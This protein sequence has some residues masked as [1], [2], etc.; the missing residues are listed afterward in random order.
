MFLFSSRQTD[1]DITVLWELD[2]RK[3]KNNLIIYLTGFLIVKSFLTWILKRQIFHENDK[4]LKCF[5]FSLSTAN[6]NCSNRK[7]SVWICE[8]VIKFT[9]YQI[10]QY[11]SCIA[12]PDPIVWQQ[13]NRLASIDWPKSIVW[14]LFNRMRR[15]VFKR[16]RQSQSIELLHF[17]IDFQRISA[18]ISNFIP[19]YS[20]SFCDCAGTTDSEN[21][22]EST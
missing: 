8:N 9:K 14:D 17:P 10:M 3:I 7:L 22:H 6:N 18:K 16:L 15:Q 4:G 12:W 20:P 11:S 2:G 1:V 5:T 21:N 19:S 13:S